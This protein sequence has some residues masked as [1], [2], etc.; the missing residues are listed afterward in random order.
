MRG[1]DT[2]GA[3]SAG[4]LTGVADVITTGAGE[5]VFTDS[6]AKWTFVGVSTFGAVMRTG[7][8]LPFSS[9]GAGLWAPDGPAARERGVN[10]GAPGFSFDPYKAQVIRNCQRMHII[11]ILQRNLYLFLVPRRCLDLRGLLHAIF[12]RSLV[13]HHGTIRRCDLGGVPAVLVA[14]VA[15]SIRAWL[16]GL[17][18]DL[19][20]HH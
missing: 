3:P 5:S 20:I 2:M 13:V 10:S 12:G 9:L 4:V 11:M 7:E 6:W 19:P 17:D 14:R 16:L 15:L 18:K 8:W 1:S